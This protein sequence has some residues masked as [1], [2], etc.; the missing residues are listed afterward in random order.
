MT[1]LTIL[2]ALF[3]LAPRAY[4]QRAPAPRVTI[5]IVEGDSAWSDRTHTIAALVRTRLELY[6]TRDQ[7]RVVRRR[8]VVDVCDSGCPDRWTPEFLRELATLVGADLMV[9]LTTSVQGSE[10]TA[11]ALV[12]R[13]GSKAVDTLSAVRGVTDSGVAGELAGTLSD[14]LHALHEQKLDSAPGAARV[15]NMSSRSFLVDIMRQRASESPLGDLRRR[16]T[17]PDDVEVRAWGGFGLVGTTGVVLRRNRGAW[18]AWRADVVPCRADV[19]IPI[20]DT[21][22]ATTVARFIALARD[23]CDASIGDV[24]RGAS[25]Y[26]ADTL[27]ITELKV[28]SGAIERA[29]D[30]AVHEGLL[31]LPAEVPRKWLMLDGFS[32]VIEVRRGAE[33]R[34]SSIEQVDKPEV[35]ADAQVKRVYDAL[36][37]L[38]R[39]ASATSR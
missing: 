13:P 26:N 11:N 10:V 18:R 36:T 3:V 37:R 24:S 15:V 34:A 6:T 12:H 4:G 25:V 7:L 33:Y 29:W 28:E 8:D 27:A 31:T 16:A 30:A 39:V 20:G 23:K 17:A 1:R 35:P 32:Y 38:I 5:A 2:L 21:A 9:E 14:M 19:A 22:S